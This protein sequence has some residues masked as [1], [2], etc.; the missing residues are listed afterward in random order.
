MKKRLLLAIMAL[1]CYTLSYSQLLTWTPEFAKEGDNITITVDATKG[2]QGLLNYAGDVYVH[3]GLITSASTNAGDWKYAPF[4]WATT[5]INGKATAAGTNKW[6]YT[7]N[8]IRSFFNVSAGETVKAIAI[9]FRDAAGNRVQRNS[10]TSIFYGNMYVPV[11][12]NG[13]YVRFIQPP[14]EPYYISTPEPINKQV[15]ETI[16]VTAFAS[17]SS[18]MKLY[19]NGTEVS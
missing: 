2:N 12:D 10:N 8:N 19:Y 14:F 4:D 9:L 17:Q 3:I 13:L 11:Y 15:G 7:I 1:A 6:S 18:A 16:S 5:P